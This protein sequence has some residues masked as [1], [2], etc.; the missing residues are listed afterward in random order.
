[1]G[2]LGMVG[3]HHSLTDPPLV[4][5][6]IGTK[7]RPLTLPLAVNS[8]LAQTYRNI[9][10]WVG[11]DGSIPPAKLA[12]E[13]QA[14]PR[15]R[16]FRVDP[17]IGIANL[18][19]EMVAR[20]S[21]SL[22]A[23][24]DDDD[25]WLPWK[26]ERQVAA[27]TQAGIRFAAMDC[28][29][30]WRD[31]HGAR[32]RH[33]P[34]PNRDAYRTVLAQAIL[35]PSCAVVRR[36]TYLALGGMEH[37]LDRVEDWDLWIRLAARYEIGVVPEVLVRRRRHIAPPALRLQ[38]H[39]KIL[40]R[41]GAEIDAQPS[42]ERRRILAHHDLFIGQC[43][44]EMGDRPRARDHLLRSWRR[45]PGLASAPMHLVRTFVGESAFGWVVG[46]GWRLV[47]ATLRL[48]GRP[49]LARRW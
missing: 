7:D 23:F 48:A 42:K 31:D 14:D 11:D 2:S 18:R 25:E 39:L 9:E 43:L 33:I 15:L 12:P 13:A 30:E 45:D 46:W 20:S 32:W 22:I 41:H 1:M 49:P 3:G 29:Y 27:M 28:G 10:V 5:V 24:L 44:A 17:S 35:P 38:A 47:T 36:D 40:E 6:A 19:N 21:G 37:E 8:V 4:S 26:L 16:T 34:D